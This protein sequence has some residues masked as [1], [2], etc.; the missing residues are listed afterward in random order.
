[1]SSAPTTP[2]APTPAPIR[3]PKATAHPSQA[4]IHTAVQ[5]QTRALC[6]LA[7]ARVSRALTLADASPPFPGLRTQAHHFPRFAPSNPTPAPHPAASKTSGDKFRFANDAH[8]PTRAAALG[9][10]SPMTK[11]GRSESRSSGES[12]C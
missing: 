12:H 11:I 7:L 5:Q 4:R 10:P 3:A 8:Y 1:M 9:A 6:G 2:T